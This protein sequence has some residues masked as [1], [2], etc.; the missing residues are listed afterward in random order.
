M[1]PYTDNNLPRNPDG[2]L[3]YPFAA[4]ALSV[5]GKST[6][7][8]TAT[9]FRERDNYIRA[10]LGDPNGCGAG[11][12]IPFNALRK[13]YARTDDIKWPPDNVAD[14]SADDD[15]FTL[16]QWDQVNTAGVS[17][18]AKITSIDEPDVILRSSE[19]T[20]RTPDTYTFDN[21]EL[22][23]Q[24]FGHG[25]TNVYF[26]DFAVQVELKVSKTGFLPTVQQ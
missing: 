22:G 1:T 6:V 13:G 8:A 12:D 4:G 25:S 18:I 19:S 21:P 10:Y 2:D 5:N 17:S 9:A 11:D 7:Q 23:L 3:K 20:F 15:Y 14:W 24:T 26:D 16:V